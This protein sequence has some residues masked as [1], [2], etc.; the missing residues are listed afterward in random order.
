MTGKSTIL[1]VEDKSSEREA[2]ARVLRL[3]DYDV[4]TAS[5]CD[6]ANGYLVESVDLVVSA[7][8]VRHAV[9][10][11]A[12][13]CRPPCVPVLRRSD[14]PAASAGIS[15]LLAQF[16]CGANRVRAGARRLALRLLIGRFALADTTNAVKWCMPQD[17]HFRS[18]GQ[19]RA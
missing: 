8:L 7:L 18:L 15:R 9:A 4:V 14:C 16:G 10:P 19:A 12:S 1:V 2:L 3:E 5:D 13:E 17:R 6:E 11:T